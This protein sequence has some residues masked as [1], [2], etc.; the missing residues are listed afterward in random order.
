MSRLTSLSLL[1]FVVLSAFPAGAAAPQRSNTSFRG[2]GFEGGLWT[3]DGCASM[4]LWFYGADYS[5][6]EGAGQPTSTNYVAGYFSSYDAC[7]NSYGWADLT[8]LVANVNAKGINATTT[9]SG[10]AEVAFGH[11]EAG[12]VEECYSYEASC[13]DAEWNFC[14]CAEECAF[15]YEAFEECY[16]PSVW[17]DDGTR[18]LGF[19]LNVAPTGDT[20]RGMNMGTQKGPNG[21]YRYR[22]TGSSRYGSMTGTVSLDG[23]PI[24]TSSAYGSVWTANSGSMSLF[25]Y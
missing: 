25:K 9:V 17:V 8:N 18:T 15:E 22:Y 10:S 4:S 12:T 1:A 13:Y 21:L 24:D 23:T 6:K 7:T 16:I 11:Y 19:S 14:D 20:F 3:D 5:T 2:D